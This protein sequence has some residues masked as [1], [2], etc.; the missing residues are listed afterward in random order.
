MKE[1]GWVL[2]ESTMLFYGV[3]ENK[4]Q[5]RFRVTDPVIGYGYV[6]APRRGIIGKA[7]KKLLNRNRVLTVGIIKRFFRQR[8]NKAAALQIAIGFYRDGSSMRFDNPFH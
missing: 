5:S 4:I 1:S 6:Y 7:N 2:T 8:K 3:P